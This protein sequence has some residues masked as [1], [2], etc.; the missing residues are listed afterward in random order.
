[1]AKITNSSAKKQSGQSEA[2]KTA[3]LTGSLNPEARR[4]VK[5][6]EIRELAFRL[7]VERGRMDGKAMEDW[8]QAEAMLRQKGRMAA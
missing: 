5:E 1:M 2:A 7:Y 3:L 6:E 8:L 4:E